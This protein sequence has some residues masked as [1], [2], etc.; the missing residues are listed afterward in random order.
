MLGAEKGQRL[1]PAEEEL[2]FRNEIPYSPSRRVAK[3]LPRGDWCRIT[4]GKT[5][6]SD[7]DSLLYTFMTSI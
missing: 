4:L 6:R 5:T 3:P 2:A 1:M 7:P